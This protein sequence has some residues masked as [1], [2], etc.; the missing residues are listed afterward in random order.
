M[1]GLDG[2]SVVRAWDAARMEEPTL[3]IVVEAD[4]DAPFTV[5]FEPSGMTYE[6]EAGQ[7][8][9]ADVFAPV[10]REIRIIHWTGGISVWPTGSV[11]TRD[12]DGHELHR[13]P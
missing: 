4:A 13:L 11:T 12:A 9:L 10:D 8:M 7:R 5:M 6:I 2:R 3:R 1:S